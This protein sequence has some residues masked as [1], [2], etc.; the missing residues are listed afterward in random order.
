MAAAKDA[1]RQAKQTLRKKIAKDHP[2]L[3]KGEA[4]D[5]FDNKWELVND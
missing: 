1:N 4:K 2:I 5:I 3:S